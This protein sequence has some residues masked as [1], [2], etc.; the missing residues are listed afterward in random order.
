MNL[1]TKRRQEVEGFLDGNL[2]NLDL[3]NAPEDHFFTIWTGEI[4]KRPQAAH[5]VDKP[6][7]Q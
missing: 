1:T 4:L 6:S 3:E 5:G 7:P 2:A